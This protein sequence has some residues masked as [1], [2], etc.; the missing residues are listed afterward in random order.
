MALR[1]PG[2]RSNIDLVIYGA[3]ALVQI[4]IL[5]SGHV[6]VGYLLMG[7]F[8]IGNGMEDILEFTGLPEWSIWLTIAVTMAMD[9]WVMYL[10]REER[11]KALK[12]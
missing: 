4:L 7:H 2:S 1:P 10:K 6:L 11:K 3:L 5:I 8:E 12:R 9:A